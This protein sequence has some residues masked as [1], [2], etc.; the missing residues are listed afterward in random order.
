MFNDVQQ[1]KLKE[2]E[3]M[4][5]QLKGQE[6]VLHYDLLALKHKLQ[7]AENRLK[8]LSLHNEESQG[9]KHSILQW[10]FN[11][12]ACKGYE[13]QQKELLD[14]EL[15]PIV[16]E[17]LKNE[18]KLAEAQAQ[19]NL[20]ESDVLSQVRDLEMTI[21]QIKNA[22]S[23]ADLN[24]TPAEAVIL[25]EKNGIKP[26]LDESDR[27]IYFRPH[28]YQ[29]KADLIAVRKM[30]TAPTSNR[31][32][33]PKEAGAERFERI[34]FDREE[35]G[36]SY[37]AE[38]NTVQVSLNNELGMAR[39][40]ELEKCRYT[41]LQ[42]LDEIPNEK[43]GALISHRTYTRGGIDLTKNAWI[44]CPERKVE[45][46]KLSNPHVHVLG[47]RGENSLGFAAPFISQLGYHVEQMGQFGW[48]DSF[49]LNQ[50][51]NIA[52]QEN[53]P[54]ARYD[55]ETSDLE[56]ESFLLDA[57]RVVALMRMLIDEKLIKTPNDF[58]NLRPQLRRKCVL[59]DIYAIFSR[60]IVK[61]KNLIRDDAIVANGRHI[62]VFAEKM[63]RAGMP[64][65]HEEVTILENQ[66]L[67]RNSEAACQVRGNLDVSELAMR[68][69]VKSALRSHTAEK[70][71]GQNDGKT[72]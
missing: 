22:K 8:N 57:N 71:S 33:T 60:S 53:I 51:D 48:E 30:F 7:I 65:T 18:I 14:Q 64:L 45:N 58:E 62:A 16:I 35:Y 24:I 20:T 27:Q 44:L 47:Y 21:N 28:Q 29:S 56:D 31:I 10:L 2:A 72:M 34:T 13:H 17:N 66:V 23:L 3:T 5:S 11:P 42:P 39:Y 68:M 38:N 4:L 46:V 26:V 55:A 19:D 69:I 43:I 40:A 63:A 67:R 9:K 52:R 70:E 50:L 59:Q 15:L 54:S 25:L 49:S 6:R 1:L 61:D 12:Q 32:S 41:V 36:F 37:P